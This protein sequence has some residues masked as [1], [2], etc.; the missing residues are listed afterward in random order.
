[1]LKIQKDIYNTKLQLQI[2]VPWLN[3]PSKE[4]AAQGGETFFCYGTRRR[5][6]HNHQE[7][8]PCGAP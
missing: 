2:P 1:M 5:M 6:S 3:L 7:W 4:A 8:L